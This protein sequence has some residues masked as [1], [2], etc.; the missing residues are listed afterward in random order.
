LSQSISALETQRDFFN[1]QNETAQAYYITQ[2]QGYLETFDGLESGTPAYEAAA[3]Q[4]SSKIAADSVMSKYQIDASYV[5]ALENA[6]IVKET[7]GGKTV[8]L[9]RL[10][11]LDENLIADDGGTYSLVIDDLESGQE[12]A[13]NLGFRDR[14]TTGMRV[15]VR[16]AVTIL[17]I[18]LLVAA[19]YTQKKKFVIDEDYYDKMIA[20]IDRRKRENTDS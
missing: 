11:A 17:P 7:A 19:L 12:S 5:P 9:G 1:R 18:V 13:A 10:G 6:M 8:E 15:W 14:R 2:I 20:E 16:A 3:E 4:V